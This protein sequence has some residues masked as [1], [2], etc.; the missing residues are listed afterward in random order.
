MRY[1]HF[2]FV[3]PPGEVEIALV[4]PRFNRTTNFP[5]TLKYW[6]GVPQGQSYLIG[7]RCLFSLGCHPFSDGIMIEI[8]YVVVILLH[9]PASHLI[10]SY[11]VG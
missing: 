8:P 9:R 5:E 11:W 7:R 3:R 10:F 2:E 4:I 1:K 6:V